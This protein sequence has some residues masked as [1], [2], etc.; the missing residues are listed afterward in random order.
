MWYKT[1][2]VPFNYQKHWIFTINVTKY[3]TLGS[4]HST[5]WDPK[6][7]TSIS[8]P[9]FLSPKTWCI[10]SCA[11]KYPPT[12]AWTNNL[13]PPPSFAQ[14]MG[15]HFTP[16]KLPPKLPFHFLRVQRDM[17]QPYT[18]LILFTW[19]QTFAKISGC[20]SSTG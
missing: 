20:V 4:I 5:H 18:P 17:T 14:T 9:P 19:M 16:C 8:F 12:H 3:P 15:P 1:S 7:W 11:T 10:S 13:R 6:F 2:L